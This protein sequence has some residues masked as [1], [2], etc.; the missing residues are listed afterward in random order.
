MI[1]MSKFFNRFL[2]FGPLCGHPVEMTMA[3]NLITVGMIGRKGIADS[4]N[5]NCSGFGEFVF[6]LSSS[7]ERAR[8]IC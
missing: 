5:S 8:R 4:S 1:R 6:L 2:H 3:Q 7:T